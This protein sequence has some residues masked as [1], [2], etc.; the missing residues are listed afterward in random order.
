MQVSAE[1]ADMMVK[2]EAL[3]TKHQLMVKSYEQHL[4]SLGSNL[5]ETKHISEERIQ[6]IENLEVSK[7]ELVRKSPRA[8]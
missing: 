2:Q 5:K 3:N 4:G 6:A 8:F 7:A 1:M